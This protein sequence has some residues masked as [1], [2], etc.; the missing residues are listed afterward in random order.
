[1]NHV[2][3]HNAHKSNNTNAFDMEAFDMNSHVLESATGFYSM[4]IACLSDS[5]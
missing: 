3:A 4:C 1:M 5:H 2:D